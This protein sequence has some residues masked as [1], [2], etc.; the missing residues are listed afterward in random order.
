MG[1]LQMTKKPRFQTHRDGTKRWM[2]WRVGDELDDKDA[3]NTEFEQVARVAEVD[4]MFFVEDPVWNGDGIEKW[5]R[6]DGA[7]WM[8]REGAIKSVTH[9]KKALSS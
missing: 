2:I 9:P 3:K 4:G 6:R 8:T 5:E 1:Y 7:G